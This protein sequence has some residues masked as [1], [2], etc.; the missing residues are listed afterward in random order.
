M[1][2]TFE[3]TYDADAAKVYAMLTDRDYL[4]T[5]VNELGHGPGEVIE[6]DA[7][8]DGGWR[9]VSTRVVELDVPGFAAKFIQPKNTVKQTDEWGP[10]RNGVREGTWKAESRGVPISL[11]GTMRLEPRAVGCVEIIRGTIKASVPLVGGK[12]EKVAAE[13]VQHNLESELE[14]NRK[15]LAVH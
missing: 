13:G 12:L 11:S 10:E 1:E 14:F 6:C 15:W 4:Q 2:I 8:G 7:A 3:H 5:K 9:S